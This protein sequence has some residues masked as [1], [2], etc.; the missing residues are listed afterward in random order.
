M[1]ERILYHQIHPLKVVTD[2]SAA[3]M[4]L[5]LFWHHRLLAGVVVSTVLPAVSSAFLISYADLTPYQHSAAGEAPL[6]TAGVAAFCR[7]Q[8]LAGFKAPRVVAAQAAPLPA[9]SAGK[10]LKAAVRAALQ[11]RLA[12]A[13]CPLPSRL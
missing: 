4:A 2:V 8:G 3:L 7:A 11:A 1:S 13:G 9:N 12:A 6:T 5:V 10:V